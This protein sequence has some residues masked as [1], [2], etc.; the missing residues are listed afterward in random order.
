MTGPTGSGKTTT[1]Y[2]ALNELNDIETKIITTE[3][4][5]EY[6][7]EGLIQ[8]PVNPDIDVTFATVL[9]AIPLGSSPLLTEVPD[10]IDASQYALQRGDLRVQVAGVATGS[11]SSMSETK[12]KPAKDDGVKAKSVAMIWVN[13]D[14]GKGGHDS[15]L[16]ADSVPP[17]SR[18]PF[19]GDGGQHSILK[20]DTP[21]FRGAR[22]CGDSAAENESL[23]S[24]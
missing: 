7:I 2:S 20:A 8:I 11:S 18:T 10:W 22:E 23:L 4:P 19:H 3:D 12:K 13:N 21:T 15:M 14:F 16:M 9:R 24:P 6:E 17:S 5:V 1:L